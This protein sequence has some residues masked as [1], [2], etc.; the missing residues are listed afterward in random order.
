[1]GWVYYKTIESGLAKR[2]S[3]LPQFVN[4]ELH[5][6]ESEWSYLRPESIC[7]IL[8]SLLG[9]FTFVWYLT[10]LCDNELNIPIQQAARD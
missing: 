6:M 1:M 7:C 4:I 2:Y 5:H 8:V 10:K 9:S 3:E